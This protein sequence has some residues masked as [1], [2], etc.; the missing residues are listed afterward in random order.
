MRFPSSHLVLVSL[1]PLAILSAMCGGKAVVDG[2]P[3]AGGATATSGTTATTGTSATTATSAATGGTNFAACSASG[4]CTLAKKSCCDPCGKPT[5][6]SFDA[7]NEE[8]VDE[9]RA[10]VCPEPEACPDCVS[11]PNPNLFAFCDTASGT[12]KGA[13]LPETEFAACAQDQ[14]CTLRNGLGCCTCGASNGYV[15]VSVAKLGDLDALLCED[16]E[17]CPECDPEPPVG[18][19]AA[20]VSNRCEVRIVA[21]PGG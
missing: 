11:E 4:T 5:L 10:S 13:D 15:A 8:L 14:D 20:C 1:V 6:A 18:I 3:G 16:A 12:C 9:H 17:P 2:L 21:P 7:V 19:E